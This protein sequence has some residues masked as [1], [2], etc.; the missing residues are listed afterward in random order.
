MCRDRQLVSSPEGVALTFDRK[1]KTLSEDGAQIK[2]LIVE[3]HPADAELILR[4]LRRDGFVVTFTIV[5]TQD[6]FRR[7]LVENPPDLV[8]S[9]Y[10]LQN[11]GGLDGLRILKETTLDIPFILVSGSLGDIAAVECIKLGATDY[12]LKDS[13]GRL[14]IALRR[15]LDEKA[16][17][18]QK[19]KL[20]T[21]LE[22]SNYDLQQFASIASHDL[23]EPLRMMSTYAE[24]LC[25]RFGELDG[26]GETDKY[27]H[28]VVD[29]AARMKAMI[30]D[31]LQ[32]SRIGN[33]GTEIRETDCNPVLE[34]AL[35][36][37]AAAI[38]EN[39]AQIRCAPLPMVMANPPQLQQ[40][41]HNLIGN[42]IKFHG[43]EAPVVEISAEQ[44]GAEWVFAV[45][46]NGIGIPSNN[47]A[48]VFQVFHRLHTRTEYAGNGIGLAICK[49]VIERLGGRIWIESPPPGGTIFKFTLRGVRPAESSNL[50]QRER[51]PTAAP[52]SA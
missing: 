20:E 10:N 31:L 27:V 6:E 5:A 9:D 11:W 18:D 33:E 43:A 37:L 19:R 30:T 15:A 42:A 36:N 40:V 28:Y 39:A 41:F 25:E 14:P 32:F 50:N 49:K 38:A 21:E 12:I 17:R 23:Q 44:R 22:R 1:N 35:L 52:L 2:V 46:D 48:T 47:M 45:A 7:Q 26:S 8:L 3:D 16:L 13:L 4:E 34:G 29:G 51:T 24:L